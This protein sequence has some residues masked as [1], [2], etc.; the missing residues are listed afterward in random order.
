MKKISKIFKALDKDYVGKLFKE[1]KLIYFPDL[2]NAQIKN[3]KIERISHDWAKETCIVKYKIY[4]DGEIVKILRGS[5]NDPDIFLNTKANAWKIINYIYKRGTAKENLV[6]RPV[7]FI[8]R[9]NLIIYEEAEGI[10]L[11]ETIQ[12]KKIRPI[13]KDLHKAAVWLAKL[14]ALPIKEKLPNAISLKFLDYQIVF[15]KILKIIPGLEAELIPAKKLKSFANIQ[16]QKVLIHNDFY[17]GNIIVN[18][19]TALGIDFDEAGLGYPLLD[20]AALYASFEFPAP[21]WKLNLLPKET[22]DLQKAFLVAYC[23][24]SQKNYSTVKRELSQFLP[25]IFLDIAYDYSLLA[26]KGW[27]FFDLASKKGH[28][29]KIKALLKK[30]EQFL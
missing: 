7:D 20:V 8:K 11:S 24:F 5:A 28:E 10:A 25:K 6:A 29:E 26:I 17:P 27:K 2:K 9:I 21:V 3:I 22:K 18:Q 16:K 15:Q 30:A 13:L 1:K 12:N 23:Q 14:H 19:K 4:F